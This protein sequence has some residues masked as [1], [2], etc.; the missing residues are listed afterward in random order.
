MISK[1]IFES[2]LGIDNRIE[3]KWYCKNR[4]GIDQLIIEILSTYFYYQRHI[5]FLFSVCTLRMNW[6][7]TFANYRSPIQQV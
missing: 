7:R 6:M 2:Y 5:V 4:G 1:Y 3:D